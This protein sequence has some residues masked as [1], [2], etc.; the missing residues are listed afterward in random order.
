MRSWIESQLA[1][2]NQRFGTSRLTPQKGADARCQFFQIKGFDQIVVG[3]GI[4]SGD[5]VRYCIARSQD[6]YWNLLAAAT[7]CLEYF[8]PAPFRQAEIQ[9]YQLIVFLDGRT[10]RSD[11]VLHP[12]NDKTVLPQ[13]LADRFAHHR[14]VFHQQQTHEPSSLGNRRYAGNA[15]V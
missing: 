11:A 12:V 14:I 2:R 4:E 8:Q 7:Q 10:L 13:S 6:Q 9:Q 15:S 1:E 5:A 3:T